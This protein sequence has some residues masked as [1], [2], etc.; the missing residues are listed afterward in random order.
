MSSSDAV[1]ASGSRPCWDEERPPGHHPPGA[2]TPTTG[3][4]RAAPPPPSTQNPW[5]GAEHRRVPGR[6]RTALC[7]EAGGV[8][9]W[10][11]RGH[12]LPA[13]LRS[14]MRWIS[15]AWTDISTRDGWIHGC[16]ASQTETVSIQVAQPPRRRL[17]RGP[18]DLFR[19]WTARQFSGAT[20]FFS[21]SPTANVQASESPR[22][23]CAGGDTVQPRPRPLPPAFILLPQ[24]L[25]PAHHAQ[26]LP[27][28]EALNTGERPG[29]LE[30]HSRSP[31]LQRAAARRPPGVQPRGHPSTLGCEPGVR[32]RP[33]RGAGPMWGSSEDG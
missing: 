30:A 8:E 10:V 24:P 31:A 29:P 16:Q 20:A 21:A 33:A 7:V 28:P 14:T 11:P 32:A 15:W 27:R 17:A 2:T 22:S 1:K 5:E 26:A 19:S 18:E 13:R 3:L 9:L 4:R 12:S 25:S 23:P 6:A